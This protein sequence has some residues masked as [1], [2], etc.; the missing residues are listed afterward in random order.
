MLN[1]RTNQGS[2]VHI[3]QHTCI[4]LTQEIETSRL[5]SDIS[6]L[7]ESSTE[8]LNVEITFCSKT[9]RKIVFQYFQIFS[10][11]LCLLIIA[12]YVFYHKRFSI[13]F[14]KYGY[15]VTYFNSNMWQKTN[16]SIKILPFLC[17]YIN[18]VR[19]FVAYYLLSFGMTPRWPSIP[20]TL[21]LFCMCS[22][23]I[24]A[25]P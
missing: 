17:S 21:R 18:I 24:S 8:F 2:S 9:L 23:V 10:T 14:F 19:F 20:R 7:W 15:K 5:V 25:S 22:A 16:I 3:R 11:S 12:Y 4:V 6:S 13:I 1:I